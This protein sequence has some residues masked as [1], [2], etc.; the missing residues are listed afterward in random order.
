M[1]GQS[2]FDTTES[3]TDHLL[4][5]EDLDVTFRTKRGDVEAVNGI[6]LHVDAGEI[7]CLVGESGSG[8]SVTAQ[9]II[10]LVPQ[11]PGEI[12][13][14]VWYKGQDL[15][16]VNSAE[17]R[18]VRAD[19]VGFIFQD[20]MSSL[21]PVHTVGRQIVEAIRAQNDVSKSDARERAI[22][23]MERV[24]ISDAGSRF[25]DYPFEFSGGMRQRVMIAIALAN[26]PDLLIADEP[27]TALD[28]TIQAQ[29]LELVRELRDELD[30][31]V[32][33][34]THDF[35]V[36]AEIADH[37]AVMYAGNVV[38]TADVYEVFDDPKHPYTRGLLE[39]IPGSAAEQGRRLTPVEGEPPDLTALEPACRFRD[40]CPDAMPRCEDGMP[41]TFVPDGD[42]DDRHEVRCYLY[43]DAP[44][45]DGPTDDGPTADA[46]IV[47]GS[48]GDLSTVDS[49]GESSHE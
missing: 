42:G 14:R 37:V 25:G 47:D 27:T 4:Q 7:L 39:S 12:S 23:L 8:K 18:R 32:I 41:A 30:M 46:P 6:D 10:D 26:E 3:A 45:A 36:V 2:H 33:W 22:E 43:D 35:G 49:G 13:G 44:N 31:A 24:G 1:D 48:N 21:N 16:T 9:S 40:R 15:R 20:P 29:V 28:V 17:L 34:I 19:E 11:P 38:E 5:I